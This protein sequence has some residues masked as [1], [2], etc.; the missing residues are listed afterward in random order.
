MIRALLGYSFCL[1]MVQYTATT[2]LL[3]FKPGPGPQ[4]EDAAFMRL[5]Y[6][7]HKRPSN[8][9]HA[10]RGS[11]A[12]RRDGSS[13]IC[14]L[15]LYYYSLIYPPCPFITAVGEDLGGWCTCARAASAGCFSAIGG[16]RL[17]ASK[18]MS[19]QCHIPSIL[20][21]SECCVLRAVRCWAARRFLCAGC[22]S[23]CRPVFLRYPVAR[24]I[25]RSL[26]LV[27]HCWGRSWLVCA[28][29]G[30]SSSKTYPAVTLFAIIA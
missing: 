7:L 4:I 30:D 17:S 21:A 27:V 5:A 24:F 22:T 1:E 8:I 25:Y 26:S 11:L 18:T 13:G 10:L 2:L 3:D 16:L 29:H 15:L 20:Y 23:A 19:S 28:L 9:L 14:L 6:L 12:A